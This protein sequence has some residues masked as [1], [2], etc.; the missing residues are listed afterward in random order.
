VDAVLDVNGRQSRCLSAQ[1]SAAW[2]G[3]QRDPSACRRCPA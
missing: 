1:A 3:Q 2:R